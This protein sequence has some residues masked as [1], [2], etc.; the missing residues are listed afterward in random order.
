MVEVYA[1]SLPER[2]DDNTYRK[3]LSCVDKYKQERIRKFH[4]W[5]DAYRS[6]LGDVLV[7]HVINEKH[8]LPI[9]G[10]EFYHDFYGKPYI[11]GITGFHFNLSHSGDWIVC[12]VDST[13]VGIDIEKIVTCDL[14]IAKRFFTKKEYKWLLEIDEQE[15]NR[16]FFELWTMKESYI[17]AVGRGLSMPLDSFEIKWMPSGLMAVMAGG[18][19]TGYTIKY[20]YIDCNHALSVCSIKRQFSE[21]IQIKSVNELINDMKEHISEFTD[22]QGRFNL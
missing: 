2:Q 12:A 7:R 19:A 22:L 3:L 5:E 9:Q 17:K 20:Y 11:K 10:M 8:S 16:S 21:K 18:S 6:L 14:D 1:L 4:R 13:T 15:K